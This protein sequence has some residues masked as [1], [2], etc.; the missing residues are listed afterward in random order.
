MQVEGVV[1]HKLRNALTIISGHVECMMI[2]QEY[3]HDGCL[4]VRK[5]INRI[6]DMMEDLKKDGNFA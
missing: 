2:K 6:I 5:G 1:I 3:N 4:E